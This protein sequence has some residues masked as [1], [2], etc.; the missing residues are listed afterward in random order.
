MS[1]GAYLFAAER[2]LPAVYLNNREPDRILWMDGSRS[3]RCGHRPGIAEFL[4]GYGY[5]SH[6]PEA[7]VAEAEGRAARWWGCA[8]VLAAH[9]LPEDLLRFGS[10]A[11][12]ASAREKG[13]G[14]A[15]LDLNPNALRSE[16]VRSTLAEGFGLGGLDDSP[17]GRLDRHAVRFLLGGWLECFLWGLLTRHAAELGLWD[18]RLGIEPAHR[19]SPDSKNEIDVAFMYRYGLW[20]VECKSGD[21]AHDPAADVLYKIEAIGRQFRALRVRTVLATTSANLLD[22]RT[23][24]LR[25]SIQDRADLYGLRI[26]GLDQIRRLADDWASADALRSALDL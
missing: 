15:R 16:P 21:Q 2:G 18:V 24:S 11:E 14:P 22:R 5:A 23:G 7:K 4:A 9:A 10:E 8:R 25:R 19:E 12:S 1:I 3:E 26:L 17:H 6:K 13:V 20:L